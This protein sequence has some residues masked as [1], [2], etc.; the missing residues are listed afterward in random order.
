MAT[1]QYQAA[2]GVV[3]QQGK[4]DGLD[5]T[6]AYV[7]LLDR[8]KRKEVRLPKGHID[9]GEDARTAALRETEEEAGFVDLVVLADLGNNTVEFD[10]K[11]D[12]F[13][14]GEHYFLMTLRSSHQSSRP[15]H[16]E[17]QF[18]PLWIEAEK[19]A[20]MLTF[21]SEQNVVRAAVNHYL[22]MI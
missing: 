2:G 10:Y 7:L 6:N 16:D 8:P 19:A 5:P 11:G 21:E 13:I 3:I 14:R 12:H 1:K 9:P 20:Q 4:I 18:K 22:Q 15:A 17:E